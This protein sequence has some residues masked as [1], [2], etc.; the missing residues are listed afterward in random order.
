MQI[1]LLLAI[2]LAEQMQNLERANP[3]AAIAFIFV[4]SKNLVTSN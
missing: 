3:S 1:N 4:T 2:Y